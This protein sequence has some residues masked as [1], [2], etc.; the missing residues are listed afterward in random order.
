MELDTYPCSL[1][2]GLNSEPVEKGPPTYH[3][4]NWPLGVRGASC[5]IMH[6][7]VKEGGKAF[8]HWAPRDACPLQQ[9]RHARLPPTPR[10]MGFITLWERSQQ[11]LMKPWLGCC[12]MTLALV[13]GTRWTA[14]PRKWVSGRAIFP[15]DAPS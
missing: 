8:A 12:L 1:L 14:L 5:S 15:H 6:L 9:C 2:L 7:Q 13:K 11:D 4:H 10:Q 3:Y